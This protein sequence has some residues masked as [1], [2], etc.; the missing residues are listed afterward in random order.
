VNLVRVADTLSC[1]ANQ[2]AGF[3]GAD[4]GN[5]IAHSLRAE[6]A[7][8]SEDGTGRGTPLVP[9]AFNWQSGGRCDLQP[10]ERTSALSAKQTPAVVFALNQRREGR[11]QDVAGSVHE[12]SG[13]QLEGAVTPMGVRRLTPTECERLQGLP[14]GWTKYG[15]REDGSVYE[16]KD[17]P[18]YRMLGN[19][20]TVPVVE[21]IARRL[22]R[23]LE[24]AP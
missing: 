13:T 17:A 19:A 1:G 24:G 23:L 8:A 15:R 7:D 3:P 20:V 16:L 10:G 4:S 21:W 6:G 18:R 11:L 9:M 5:L 14:D 2:T 12:P 22:V